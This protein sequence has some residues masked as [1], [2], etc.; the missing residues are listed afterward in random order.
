M[1]ARCA[2]AEKR[3]LYVDQLFA[4]QKTWAFSDKP[5]EPLLALV[6]T[7]GMSQTDFETCLRTRISTSR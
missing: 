2:G 5:V 4:Q 3:N 7:L 6:K 1:L